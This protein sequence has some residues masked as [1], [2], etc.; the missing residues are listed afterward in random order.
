M[1]MAS[2]IRFE[3]QDPA[4]SAPTG[5]ASAGNGGALERVIA[6]LTC[7]L[8]ASLLSAVA[9]ARRV[10][11]SAGA[12]ALGLIAGYGAPACAGHEVVLRLKG[13]DFEVV[14][15]VRS[16]DGQRWVVAARG[17]GELALEAARFD[18]VEGDCSSASVVPPRS[19]L[20]LAPA[21]TARPPVLTLDSAPPLDRELIP[22]LI[23]AYAGHMGGSAKQMIG[24]ATDETRFK[25]IDRHGLDMAEINVRRRGSD[26]VF[27]ALRGGE[28]AIGATTRTQTPAEL[29]QIGAPAQRTAF[30]DNEHVLGLDGLAVIVPPSSPAKRLAASQLARI[31][32]G[33]IRDW[34]AVG[35]P[36]GPITVYAGGERT[37]EALAAIARPGGLALSPAA[38]RIADE[39]ALS[40]AV[41]RDPGAIGIT[42][43]TQVR[44]ARTLD[45][46]LAC[47]LVARPTEFAI[48]AEEYP[49]GRRLY[50]YSNGKPKEPMA[51]ELIRF[52]ASRPGQQAVR[53]GGLIDQAVAAEAAESEKERL[54]R[55]AASG[56]NAATLALGRRFA[57]EVEK[58]H[59]LSLT[60]RFAL[61]SSELD[62]KARG[63][64]QRLAELLK[65]PELKGRTI[66]L[67]GFTDAP[68]KPQFNAALSQKRAD[69]I[70]SAVL[71]ELASPE[72]ARRVVARGFGPAAPVAC[73]GGDAGQFRNRR[74][75]V[76]I[77][78]GGEDALAPP[79]A[80]LKPERPATA[81]AD[82]LRKSAA[83]GR[84]AQGERK[85]QLR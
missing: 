18:C 54:A 16:F 41:A 26:H 44:N 53:D 33:E 2:G 39:A 38:T 35:L 55:A 75:E 12:I 47:G 3:C 17:F 69:E 58:A 61:N 56:R 34:K 15:E 5:G 71:K 60:F 49:L 19:T 84:T 50:V 62:A 73:N 80:T 70:R 1:A 31:F 81:A 79:V 7:R 72:T 68:G 45:I 64:I 14:G 63:D 6:S 4:P 65:T 46:E 40:D 85:R 74:V 42:S 28:A 36:P 20:E 57:A 48:K 37:V 11:T 59:R 9:P 22:S 51:Q 23:R 66:M 32:S 25:L 82:R 83:A 10:A 24:A 8:A 43:L 67:I 13:G 77:R 78:D 52:A 21:S 27:A 30:T 76:W 29:A